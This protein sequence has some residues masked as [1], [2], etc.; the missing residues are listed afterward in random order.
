MEIFGNL[1]GAKHVQGKKLYVCKKIKEAMLNRK[2]AN[3]ALKLSSTLFENNV[4]TLCYSLYFVS[5]YF[6][7]YQFLLYFKSKK[8]GSKI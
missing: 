5:W 7:Y 2:D 1:M 8:G 6:N 3:R 4:H